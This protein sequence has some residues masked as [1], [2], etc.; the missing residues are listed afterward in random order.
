M[1]EMIP[2]IPVALSAL[3]SVMGGQSQKAA[4]EYKAAQMNQQAGQDRASAQR[5]AIEQQRQATLA[6]SRLRAVAGG[7]AGDPTVVKLSEDIAGEGEYRALTSLYNGEE[8]AR[9]LEMAAAGK[10]LEGSQAVTASY[11]KAGS[12]ILGK[13]PSLHEKY[14][15]GK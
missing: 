2:F 1:A 11:L 12:S 13:G 6:Q 5:D 4:A 7:G 10:Q 3:S 9:G 8:R 14:G 15:L